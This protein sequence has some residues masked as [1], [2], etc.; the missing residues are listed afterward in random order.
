MPPFACATNI[1]KGD[2]LCPPFDGGFLR[3]SSLGRFLIRVSRNERKR[4]TGD[5]KK[6]R[7][8]RIRLLGGLR[9]GEGV[10]KKRIWGFQF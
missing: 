9:R 8:R 7:R 5:V 10:K 3:V 4:K 1:L 2:K 6:I